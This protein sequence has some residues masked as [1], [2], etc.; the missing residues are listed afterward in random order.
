MLNPQFGPLCY[1]CNFRVAD[2]S[3]QIF[4]VEP[5]DSLHRRIYLEPIG[6]SVEV[7]VGRLVRVRLDMQSKSLL[8]RLSGNDGLFSRH[9]LRVQHW[10]DCG[11]REGC[12]IRV[13]KPAVT[14]DRGAWTFAASEDETEVL[15]SWA[16]VEEQ[17]VATE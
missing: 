11:A 16:D 2:N 9:R 14:E 17:Q 6:S 13:V 7:E 3:T 12:G 1:L 8:V 5:V 15:L 4:T 10:A